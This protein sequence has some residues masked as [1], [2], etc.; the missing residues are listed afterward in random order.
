MRQ[1]NYRIASKLILKGI[2]ENSL[3][4]DIRNHNSKELLL[5]SSLVVLIP[6]S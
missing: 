3:L 2:L 5:Q 1:N 4:S 6:F